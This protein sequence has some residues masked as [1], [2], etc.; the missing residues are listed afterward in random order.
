MAASTLAKV[1]PAVSPLEQAA[2]AKETSQNPKARPENVQNVRW[3]DE[4]RMHTSLPLSA[5]LGPHELPMGELDGSGAAG[6]LGNCEGHGSLGQWRAAGRAAIPGCQDRGD[7]YHAAPN[8]DLPPWSKMISNP[9]DERY[10]GDSFYYG[11]EANDFLMAQAHLLPPK[12]RVLCLAEGEGRNAVYLAGLGHRVTAVDGSAVGLEKA[13]RFAQERGVSLQTVVA[14][15][16]EFAIGEAQWDAVVSVWCHLPEPLRRQV[17]AGVIQGLAPGGVLILEAYHPRQIGRGTGGPPT[18]L[19]MMTLEA[20][21][22]ELD[23][24]E[25]LHAGEI[26][27]DVR[28]G[29]GHNGLSAVT[30]VVARK[31]A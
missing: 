29:A 23:G 28:E 30:Q 20:L 15:L 3:I 6:W 5:W 31:P 7:R 24:L 11:T 1:G 16:A 14:D 26:E 18:P 4:N 19:L 22:S 9:W 8:L 2:K 13:K 21:R 10:A 25:W 27:R 12:A 17:H